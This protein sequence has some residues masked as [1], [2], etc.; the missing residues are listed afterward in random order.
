MR[1]WLIPCLLMPF[2]ACAE[3]AWKTIEADNHHRY[4]I[5]S[6]LIEE[7]LSN[8]PETRWVLRF[9][10]P[11]GAF[12]LESN[13][14]QAMR[15]QIRHDP[16]VPK[17]IGTLEYLVKEYKP[18]RGDGSYFKVS[19]HYL[20]SVWVDRKLNRKYLTKYYVGN[21]MA[22]GYGVKSLTIDF[23]W[24]RRK[25]FDPWMMRIESSWDPQDTWRNWPD[26]R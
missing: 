22:N 2:P 7:D 23:P 8:E 1:A 9:H 24:D 6:V 19:Q 21:K 25:E 11:D 5:P 17:S 26:G 20:L 15:N 13:G 10:S 16:T 4:E 12:H 14:W 18:K 3:E